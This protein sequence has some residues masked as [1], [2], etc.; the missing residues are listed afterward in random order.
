L[1]VARTAT[2]AAIASASARGLQRWPGAPQLEFD[3]LG[4]IMFCRAASLNVIG[5]AFNNHAA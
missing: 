4:Q 3:P 5:T 2:D 1:I